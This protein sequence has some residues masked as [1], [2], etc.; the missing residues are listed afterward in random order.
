MLC[1]RELVRQKRGSCRCLVDDNNSMTIPVS[2]AVE[3]DLDSAVARR[4]VQCCSGQAA[5]IYGL[6]GKPHLL[7]SLRGY[8]RAAIRQPWFVMVDLD[9][10]APC[11]G[12]FVRDTLPEP[13]PYMCYRVCTRQVESWLLADAT[14]F[15]S[16]FGLRTRRIPAR[17]DTLTDAKAALVN[18]CSQSSRRDIREMIVPTPQSLRRVGVGYNGILSNF[19][20]SEWD[21]IEAATRSPSLAKCIARVRGLVQG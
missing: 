15:A 11:A 2:I 18:L 14:R 21:P 4:I 8:N 20:L 3:G 7:Q 1:S 5:S 19:A 12:Q 16:A 10:S 9:Q 17:P 6:R 13:S